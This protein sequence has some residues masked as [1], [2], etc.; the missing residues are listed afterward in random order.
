M[1]LWVISER[2][3]SKPGILTNGSLIS[4]GCSA[5]VSPLGMAGGREPIGSNG[6][7]LSPKLGIIGLSGM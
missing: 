3:F 7:F 6:I 2:C 5:Q 1:Q 4:L